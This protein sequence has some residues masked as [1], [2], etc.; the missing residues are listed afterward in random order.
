MSMKPKLSADHQP[1]R[2]VRCNYRSGRETS[3]FEI[4]ELDELHDLI[5]RGLSWLEI[6]EITVNYALHP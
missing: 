4:E 5:E 6:D 2:K 1:R 3:V